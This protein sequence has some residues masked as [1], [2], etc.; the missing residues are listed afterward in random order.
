MEAWM[1]EA[2]L[3]FQQLSARHERPLAL[4]FEALAHGGDDRWFHPHPLTA[5]HAARLAGYR[6]RDL[7]YVATRGEAVA[8]YGLLRGWDEGYS[9]PSLGIAVH[10]QARGCGLARAFMLFLH[11]AARARGSRNIRLKVYPA[12]TAARRLYESLGYRFEPT[13]D[14]Q[15][16]GV[17]DLER[18]GHG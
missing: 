13:P 16:L 8:A 1:T 18:R 15:L 4:F 11:S 5:E 3:E 7:Y 12:N 9:T 6:G 2:P 17:C 10:P 14:G